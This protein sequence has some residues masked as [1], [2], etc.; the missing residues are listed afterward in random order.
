[1]V[2]PVSAALSDVRQEVPADLWK[3]ET[4]L[5]GQARWRVDINGMM[6]YKELNS[7]F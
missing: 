5:I 2:I 3:L 4:I 1:M 6:N 7:D